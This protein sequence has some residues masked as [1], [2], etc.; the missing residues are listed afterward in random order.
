MSGTTG[1]SL[2]LLNLDEFWDVEFANRIF[3]VPKN[4]CVSLQ[5]ILSG[6]TEKSECF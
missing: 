1:K 6:K 4:V 5:V 3:H 2:M